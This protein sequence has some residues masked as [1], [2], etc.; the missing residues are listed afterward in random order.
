MRRLGCT[1]CRRSPS[2][3]ASPSGRRPL[4]VV[5]LANRGTFPVRQDAGRLEGSDAPEHG[6]N[7]S[8]GAKRVTS[9]L[10]FGE[11]VRDVVKETDWY[12]RLVSRVQV[13]GQHVSES[14]VPAGLARHYLKYSDEPIL[15]AAE[16]QAR[17]AHRG[18]WRVTNPQPLW[19]YGAHGTADTLPIR[20]LATS[21][22]AQT[23]ASRH[24]GITIELFNRQVAP[25]ALTGPDGG[26]L[27][28]VAEFVE[29]FRRES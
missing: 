11:T 28:V 20:L 25:I 6:Q 16:H 7:V 17:T 10:V 3:S 24:E 2:S 29:V 13:A 12:G 15:A 23:R 19:E 8:N 1:S 9:Q 21:E 18:V 5:S 27:Q 4:P 22:E 26:D 14:L